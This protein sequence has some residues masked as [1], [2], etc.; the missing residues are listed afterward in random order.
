MRSASLATGALCLCICV[1]YLQAQNATVQSAGGLD[2]K[3][4]DNSVDPCDDFYEYA[5][6]TW[7]KNNPIP[8]DES[9]WG[10]FNELY[11][12]NQ[13]ILRDILEDSARHQNASAIDQKIG[14][15]YQSCMNEALIEQR[16]TTP[17]R[18]ELDRISQIRT[19]EQLLDEVARLHQRQVGVFFSFNSM[20]DP[21]NARMMI[22]D[23]DQGGLGL[24]ERDYYFRTDAQSVELRKKYVSH[25][26]KLFQLIGVAEP[27]AAK[28]ANSVMSLETDLAKASLD[29]TTRRDPQKL[30]HEMSSSDLE[31]LSPNFN[32]E[33]FFTAVT[34]PHFTML[35]VDVPE[36]VKTFS[37]MTATRSMDDLKDY[38]VWH[39]LNAGARLLPKAF[40]DENFDFY[41]RTLSGAKELKPRW[42][43]CVAATDDELGE[44]LGRKFVEK[45]FG[46]QGKQRTLAMVHEIE[47][48]MGK[49]IQSLSW[50]SPETKK[51]ALV[52]L[53]AVANKIGYP[54]KWRDYSTVNIVND[55]YFGNWFRANEFESKRERDKIGKPVDRTEWQMSPPTVN[56]Y[57]NPTEN[58]INFPA[59]ILQ[60]PFYSNKASDAVNYGSIGVVIGH[61]L[62]HGFDDAGRQ[63]DAEGN[64]KDWWQ[65]TDAEQFQKL[66]DCFVNEYSKFTAAPGVQV[67]GRLTL[68]ENTA[69]NGGIRLAYL[70]LLDDLAKKGLSSTE[71]TGEYTP[72]QQFFL[73]FAQVWCENMRPEEARQLALGDPHAPGR[74]RVD[75]VVPN[76]PQFSRAFGC[77]L[78]E[79]MYAAQGCRVW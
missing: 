71:K 20:P 33:Q 74:F 65:K 11:D 13:A 39:Y 63:F 29:I 75:G 34:A 8:A 37:Q 40:V 10:R 67:N 22:A 19:R 64:L 5:C 15:F 60:P 50:M 72:E 44:A 16:G 35:N 79:K 23:V 4:I 54:E 17:L 70:A 28:K 24:P 1:G 30:V 66:A 46:E 27:D 76:M 25:I 68:G 43:R 18:P 12:R 36:F 53:D 57:Y 49:D 6:G 7:M 38:L 52:K 51:Q 56:A 78:G 45:T 47:A 55:D 73:G 26:A 3:A 61:E 2:L 48:Q 41:G 9:S 59:G 21:K 77:K 14:G 32:F 42:K 31:Q 58:N 62:T 69:D